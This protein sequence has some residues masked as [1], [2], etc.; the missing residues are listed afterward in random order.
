VDV[1]QAAPYVLLNG[2]TAPVQM[3]LGFAWEAPNLSP[4]NPRQPAHSA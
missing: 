4:S 1:A 3:R 2:R